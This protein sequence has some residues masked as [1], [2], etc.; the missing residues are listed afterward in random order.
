MSYNSVNPYLSPTSRSKPYIPRSLRSPGTNPFFT[1]STRPNDRNTSLEFSDRTILSPKVPMTFVPKGMKVHPFPSASLEAEDKLSLYAEVERLTIFNFELKRENEALTHEVE[2]QKFANARI[3]ELENIIRALEKDIAR[4]EGTLSNLKGSRHYFDNM[5]NSRMDPFYQEIVDHNKTLLNEVERLNTRLKDMTHE[6][7]LLTVRNESIPNIQQRLESTEKRINQRDQEN[8]DY[9]SRIDE[10]NQEIDGLKRENKNMKKEYFDAVTERDEIKKKMEEFEKNQVKTL[11]K[12]RE[13]IEIERRAV[14]DYEKS[15]LSARYVVEMRK[16][17]EELEQSKKLAENL[18]ERLVSANNEV[19]QLRRKNLE[20]EGEVDSLKLKL[21]KSDL[22]RENIKREVE[23]ELRSKMDNEIMEL[24]KRSVQQLSQ[25]E[26][27]IL[28]LKRE[29]KEFQMLKEILKQKETEIEHLKAMASNNETTWEKKLEQALEFQNK[30]ANNKFLLEKSTLETESTRLKENIAH[31]EKQIASL[32]G[33]INRLTNL[34]NSKVSEINDLQRKVSTLEVNS[35]VSLEEERYKLEVEKKKALEELRG[36]LEN[37]F[38][39]RITEFNKDQKTLEEK[40]SKLIEEN[41]KLSVVGESRLRDLD[42]LKQKLKLVEETH[43]EQSQEVEKR[44]ELS[45]RLA[46]EKEVNTLSIQFNSEKT[47]LESSIS[48]LKGEVEKNKI[49]NQSQEEEIAGYKKSIRES[50]ELLQ[51][52]IR[53]N[54]ELQHQHETSVSDMKVQ[55]ENF[56]RVSVETNTLQLKSE[57]EKAALNSQLIQA[58][59]K[60]EELEK[61]MVL[62]TQENERLRE[63]QNTKMNEIDSLRRNQKDLE[64]RWATEKSQLENEVQQ[65]KRINLDLKEEHI[66]LISEKSQHENQI[67]QLKT[68]NENG[69]QELEKLYELMNQRKKE[70]DHYIKQ[71]DEM[72]KE[73][74]R[75]NKLL[76]DN[77]S[78][79]NITKD[80]NTD[81]ERVL[82]DHQNERDHYKSQA[83]KLEIKL[84]Q[85]HE[86]LDEK[87][88]ELNKSKQKYEQAMTNLSAQID[89]NLTKKLMTSSLIVSGNS[90]TFGFDQTHI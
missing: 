27:K 20:K 43:H 15:E 28:Q 24:S 68:I 26:E 76:R 38:Q 19:D 66:K 35:R 49:I 59:E 58:K 1:D 8:R 22:D 33:E 86:E 74:D 14:V 64:E 31:C 4:K 61:R 67:K 89:S 65:S 32:N 45:Q 70:Y 30:S 9:I 62:F 56:K 83:E 10:L 90:H 54:A 77:H 13:Q 81:L 17:E 6:K 37:V 69:R 72:K 80:R 50:E 42:S 88:T 82:L 71:N 11:E 36:T 78:D 2:N 84:Q 52:E 51:E 79:V 63:L 53:K 55:F 57:V 16:K 48:I 44:A 87:I 3:P 34:C 25:H 75:L 46:L 29:L 23:I 7:D 5:N 39:Q 40:M 41:N 60:I 21:T 73:V 18:E 12:I 47:D 85:T